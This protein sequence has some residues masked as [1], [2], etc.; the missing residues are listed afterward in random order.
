MPQRQISGKGGVRGII[1]P[2]LQDVTVPQP[3]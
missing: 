3:A 1:R 2:D